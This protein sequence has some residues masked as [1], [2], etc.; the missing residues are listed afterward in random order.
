[1]TSVPHPPSPRSAQIQELM[2]QVHLLQ[3]QKKELEHQK[4][5]VE[6]KTTS[7]KAKPLYPDINQLTTL[8][9]IGTDI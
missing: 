1:D 8:L 5:A 6:A 4:V 9:N 3:S 7:L 2:A